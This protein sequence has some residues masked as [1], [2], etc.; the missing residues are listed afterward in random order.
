MTKLIFLSFLGLALT[1]C[2]SKIGMQEIE[3]QKGSPV[4]ELEPLQKIDTRA[5]SKINSASQK[6]EFAEQSFQGISVEDSYIKKLSDASGSA[7]IVRASVTTENQ[8]LDRL[9]LEDFEKKKPTILN[10]LKKS[11]PIFKKF[12]P[13]KIEVVIAHRRG[14]YEPLWKILYSDKNGIPWEVKVNNHLQV[15]S[16]KRVGSQFHDT[17]AIVFPKGP[18]MSFLQEVALKGLAANPTL[19]NNRLFVSSQAEFKI[20]DVTAPLKF[21]PQDTR[22][23]QV[24]VFYFLDESL[25]WFERKLNVT[26]PFQLHAEVHM[27]APEKT[28]SAFYYDGKIRIGAGDDETYSRI[29]QDPSIIIH[30]S[31]H[32]LVDAVARL[33]FEGEGGSLNEG[34]ADFFTA[35]QLDNPNM[36]EASYLK[37]PFRRSVVNNYKLSDKTGG[38]Y[39]DSGIASGTLWELRL[40]L[41]PDKAREIAI[42]TLNRLV[43]SSDFGD[44]GAQLR[45]V[46]P[47]VLNQQELTAAL[48][49]VTARG[50]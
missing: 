49:I 45:S 43:P 5:E 16:V 19:S 40:K 6:I 46:L 1:A 44:F 35:L 41:G 2:N 8:K 7:L 18:K 36:A 34:F 4:T 14:F 28:N 39:H 27:G 48:E 15:S 11:F 29:P 47:E 3:W 21:T 37:G 25:N 32:A 24:Q 22:F 30:E 42:L 13:E 23:D 33:P 26:I 38:L 20:S 9:R 12:P 10:D 31:V 50:F 17:I